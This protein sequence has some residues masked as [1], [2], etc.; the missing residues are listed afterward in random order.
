MSDIQGNDYVVGCQVSVKTQNEEVQGEVFAFDEASGT[1]LIRQQGSTPFHN[2]LRLLRT[3]YIKVTHLSATCQH[4]CLPL[5]GPLYVWPCQSPSRLELPAVSICKTPAV[6]LQSIE[7]AS[8]PIDPL[9]P[10]P[11]VDMQR[12]RDRETKALQV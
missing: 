3:S 4:L 8:E 12:C 7:N 9:A 10:L 6:M 2:H 11:M 1:V 5:P